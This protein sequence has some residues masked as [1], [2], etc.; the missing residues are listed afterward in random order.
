MGLEDESEQVKERAYYYID[1][2]G[3]KSPEEQAS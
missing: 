2:L 1:L 3:E